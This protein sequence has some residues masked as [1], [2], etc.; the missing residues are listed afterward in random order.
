MKL[1]ASRRA[2]YENASG[3]ISTRASCSTF[4]LTISSTNH[5]VR[6]GNLNDLFSSWEVVYWLYSLKIIVKVI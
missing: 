3:E 4:Q 1:F 2:G 5:T 6:A